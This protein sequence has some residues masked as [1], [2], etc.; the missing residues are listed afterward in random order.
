MEK[1]KKAL[2]FASRNRLELG[3]AASTQA[4]PE[5]SAAESVPTTDENTS[6]VD[7]LPHGDSTVETDAAAAAAKPVRT[8]ADVLPG[9]IEFTQTRVE[10]VPY[11]TL[12]ANKVIL[13]HDDE[14][15]PSR[16]YQ[17]LSSQLIA[18]VRETGFNSIAV[19][20]PGPEEGKS[21]TA[22]NLAV[23]ITRRLERTALVV[24]LDFRR[25]STA[26]Y[27]GLK[28]QYGIEHVLRGECSI[29]DALVSPG[30]SR[31]TALPITQADSSN[32]ALLDTGTCRSLAHELKHR[33]ANRIVLF[34]LPPLLAYGDALSFLPLVDAALLVVTEGVTKRDAIEHSLQVLAGTR[35]LGTV[36]N[37]SAE[38]QAGYG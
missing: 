37:Q 19:V 24:D 13:P 15:D 12:T 30:I 16:A 29:A 20:S 28:P 33:Y 4:R 35:L 9:T 3:N 7:G 14:S 5:E 32:A 2:E 17:I 38:K 10:R 6:L 36:L 21:L 34:D 18:K 26:R 22:I 8:S 1:I 23:S 25:P 31:L 11:S 27:L